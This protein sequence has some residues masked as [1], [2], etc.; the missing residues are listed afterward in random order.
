MVRSFGRWVGGRLPV[1]GLNVRRAPNYP[2]D[3]A[4]QPIGVNMPKV[5]FIQGGGVGIDQEGERPPVLRRRGCPSSSRFSRRPGG[6]RRARRALLAGLEPVERH[7]LRQDQI[8]AAAEAT[9]A[10]VNYNVHF[11][12]AGALRLGAADS[13]CGRAAVTVQRREPDAGPRDH[14][15]P[16]QHRRARSRARRGAELQGRHRRGLRALLP[17]RLHPRWQTGPQERALHPQGQH[18][19]ALRR[20]SIS[21]ASAAWPRSSQPSRRRR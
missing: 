19:Q 1:A 18:S 3:G 12:R 9:K 20:A 6:A 21:N 11:R 10:P 7:G 13:Q 17:L 5:A 2:A 8:A 15:R 14:R 16:L 4:S